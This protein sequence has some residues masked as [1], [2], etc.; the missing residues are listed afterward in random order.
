MRI[1]KIYFVSA[2]CLIMSGCISTDI[3]IDVPYKTT[4][5]DT[6][7][8]EIVKMDSVSEKDLDIFREQLNR[9]FISHKDKHEVSA[10]LEI[11]IT[12]TDYYMR[13]GFERPLGILFD[14]IVTRVNLID[15]ASRETLSTFTVTSSNS[16]VRGSAKGLLQQHVDKIASY[17]ISGRI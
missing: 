14:S 10:G 17:V 12:F 8:Y 15:K 16:T 2:I 13:H 7:S 6:Y 3:V 11:E 9:R 4:N 1:F 5:S